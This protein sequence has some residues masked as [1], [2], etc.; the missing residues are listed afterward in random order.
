MSLPAEPN[1]IVDE[2]P[3][4]K[5]ERYCLN[6]PVTVKIITVEPGHQ[7]SLQL[8]RHRDE[9]WVTL[10]DGLIVEIDDQT[11]HAKAGD[12]FFVRRGQKHRVASPQDRTVRFLEV[13]FGDFAETDIERLADDYGRV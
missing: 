5:F 9:L 13:A 7:L 12:R 4:G 10:D 3:W 1:V 8:H 11:S 2:R 6:E